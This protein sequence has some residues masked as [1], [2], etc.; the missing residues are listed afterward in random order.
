MPPDEPKSHIFFALLD[1]PLV[2]NWLNNIISPASSSAKRQDLINFISW[3]KVTTM[4][5]IQK[6][7]REDIIN[8]RDAMLGP[9]DDRRYAIR[10]VKRNMATISKFLEMLR[11]NK[12]LEINVVQGVERPKLTPKAQPKRLMLLRPETFWMLRIRKP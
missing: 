9:K 8:W 6:I 10:T 5:D 1:D 11:D 12:I 7:K 2:K 4:E 3:F